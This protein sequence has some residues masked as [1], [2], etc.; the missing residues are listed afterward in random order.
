MKTSFKKLTSVL[1]SLLML[2]SL[3]TVA[4]ISVSAA[5]TVYL[6]VS[7]ASTGE[8][9]Y[10]AWIWDTG[11]EG[12]FV[13]MTLDSEGY[14]EVP[15]EAGQNVVFVRMPAGTAGSWDAKW[16]QSVDTAFDGTNNLCTLTWS[17]TWG[18]DMEVSWSSKGGTPTTP[19]PT[20]PTIPTIAT[21]ETTV[22]TTA[23]TTVPTDPTEPDEDQYLYVSA[24]S[25]LNTTGVKVKSLGD[26]VT[27]TY[28][29]TGTA[30]DDCQAELTYDSTKLSLN[31]TYN[32]RESM[33]PV[34][35]DAQYNLNAGNGKVLFNFSGINNKYDFTAGGGL[36]SMVFDRVGSSVGTASV[37]LNITDMDSK[38]TTYIEN[39]NIKT[40]AGIALSP[41]VSAEEPT[42]PTETEVPTG[43]ANVNVKASSN[44]STNVTAVEIDKS[45]AKVTFDLTCPGKVAFGDVTVTYDASKLALESKYN[46]GE[47]MFTTI[48]EGV[49]YR[50]D[51]AAG[52]MKFNFT[53]VDS[54]NKTGKYD[55]SKGAQLVTLVF[56]IRANSTGDAAINLNVTDLGTFDT[57]YV[58]DGSVKD[59]S[60]T[61]N[62]TVNDEEATTSATEETEVTIATG[63]TGETKP[64]ESSETVS[65]ESSET[66]PTE[67]SETLPTESSETQPTSPVSTFDYYVVGSP[68][69]FGANWTADPA[70]G[71][72]KG[73]DNRYYLAIENAPIGTFNFKVVDSN[74][75]WHPDGMGNDGSVTVS[76]SGTKV[77][78]IYD[79]SKGYAIASTNGEL[80]VY[81]EPTTP[82]K[83]TETTKPTEPTKPTEATQPTTKPQSVNDADKTISKTN[84][85]NGDPKGSTFAPITLKATSSSKSA[86][87]LSWA[88]VKGAKG[89]YIYGAKCGSNLKKIKTVSSGTTKFT[90][91]KLK[92]GTY[93]KYLVMAYKTQGG[94]KVTASMSKVVHVTTTGKAYGNPSKVVYKK[95]SLSI[96]R[97]QSMTLK[98]TVKVTKKIK[99]HVA[100][101]F[102][103]T[104]TK[105]VTVNSKGKIT[106]KSKGTATVYMY[107][108]NGVYDKVKVTVK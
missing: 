4:G 81:T 18:G 48:S 103:S 25:N 58:A 70:N 96:K 60:A 31:S 22:P 47:S 42:K 17:T 91:K 45:T 97:G 75:G 28:T 9:D 105:V 68:E 83:P 99:K 16:N 39:G 57:D 72:T 37:Y 85:D 6:D 69:L 63:T 59:S 32:T 56:T 15:M 33:F 13:Q 1:L 67:S 98:P 8:E 61:V 77:I 101:R 106:A 23:P 76:E 65:T 29:L 49:T 11:A 54:V 100:T 64:T 95:S 107:A 108:Q 93:Y 12:S 41:S 46:T 2:F 14:Y 66:T 62:A 26:K 24:K 55:F 88:K 7:G 35:T 87:K 73:I 86:V 5:S 30:L 44:L 78:F 84:T 34:A 51:V 90:V 53:G 92:K 43:D 21:T 40:T 10:W 19:I 20:F 52:K 27:V 74:G 104:N 3:F 82:T 89:Y 36:V 94:K 79:E 50:L 38:E 102:E 80:P 71:M